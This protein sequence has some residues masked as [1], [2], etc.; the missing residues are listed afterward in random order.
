MN[1][2]SIAG[3]LGIGSSVAYAASKGALINMTKSLARALGSIR[4]NAMGPRFIKE[5]VEKWLG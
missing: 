3:V 4:I 5:I 2:A 1:V